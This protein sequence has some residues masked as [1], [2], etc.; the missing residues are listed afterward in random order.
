MGRLGTANELASATVFL[1]S[2]ESCFITGID[3][4]VDVAPL[5]DEPPEDTPMKMEATELW[6]NHLY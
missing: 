1:A 6:K 2:D 3:L 5:L 4:S